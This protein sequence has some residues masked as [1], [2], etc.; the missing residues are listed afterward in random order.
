MD[1]DDSERSQSPKFT[2]R[3]DLDG[4]TGWDMGLNP[5]EIKGSVKKKDQL[6]YV[7]LWDNSTVDLV[8]RE[9][10]KA[11]CPHLV[12]KYLE[13]NLVWRSTKARSE[14]AGGGDGKTRNGDVAANGSSSS[15]KTEEL[16]RRRSKPVEP[17]DDSDSSDD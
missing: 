12:I 17:S 11:K 2:L 14:N 16:K 15:K 1:V 8:W 3:E 6:F 7:M 13:S 10:A 5:V 4:P 9:D